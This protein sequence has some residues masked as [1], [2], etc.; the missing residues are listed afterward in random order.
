MMNNINNIDEVIENIINHFD[1][2]WKQSKEI[3]K[4]LEILTENKATFK[5]AN[6]LA[7]EVGN[8][9]SK[10]FKDTIKSDMLSNKKM[11]QEMAEKLVNSSLRKAHEVISDYSTGVMEN[12]NKVS[13]I[14][15]GVVTPKFNQ[16][17]A[18]GIIVRL[19][20]DDY[21]KIKWI[22]DEPVKT[23]CKG[24]VDDTVKVNVKYHSKLG[25]KPV[26]IRISSGKCCK[27]C[28]KIAGKYNYPEVPKDV[29]RRHSH[30]DCI[31]EYFPGDGKKQNVWTKKYTKQEKRHNIQSEKLTKAEKD[32][33]IEKRIKLSKQNESN[34][35]DVRKQCLK[36]DIHYNQIKKHK[37]IISEKDIIKNLGG[38]DKTK[39]SCSSVALAYVGNK[40]GYDVLD[41]RGGKSCEIFAQN[42]TIKKI[43]KLSGIKSFNVKDYNDY[44]AVLRLTQ[45]MIKDKEYYL[46]TGGHAAIIRKTSEGLEYLELQDNEILNGYKKLNNNV[47]TKRFGCKKSHNLKYIGKVEAESILIDVD[48]LKNNEEFKKIL[49]FINTNSGK[50]LKGSGGSVK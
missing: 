20:R 32:A 38:L 40:G 12:L 27:W 31:V 47:L 2:G 35:S 29:Y 26:V 4:A 7:T 1:K 16:N 18:N 46:A 15:G 42:D 10:V 24:I 23:F 41:F 5:N 28:D 48:S 9:L 22:L 14:S 21:D 37:E 8:I 45:N 34:I 25:L 44:N 50:Q 3:K 39:G 30:C 49:G 43:S 33:K 13:K 36:N 17:K 6:D 19:V 11:Y